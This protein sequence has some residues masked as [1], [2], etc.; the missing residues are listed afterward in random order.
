MERRITPFSKALIH[1]IE[2]GK[3]VTQTKIS[4]TTG[5]KQGMISGMKTGKRKGTED[6]RRSIAA[7]FNKTYEEFLE[8]GQK[9]IDSENKAIISSTDSPPTLQTTVSERP[10]VLTE[11]QKMVKRFIDPKRGNHLNQILLKIEELDPDALDEIVVML[12]AKLKHM[13]A[14]SSPMKDI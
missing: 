10:I 8:I 13:R 2:T 12:Q 7:F 14:K 6:S 11:H 9:L 3:N 5:I 1:F 4:K